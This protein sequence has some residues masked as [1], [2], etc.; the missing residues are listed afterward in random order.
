MGRWEAGGSRPPAFSLSIDNTMD[1]KHYYKGHVR[2]G[3]SDAKGRAIKF[4]E[5]SNGDGVIETSD[6]DVIAP[7]ELR[8]RER[9]GG[10][11]AISKEAF[12]KFVQEDAD[13][14]KNATPSPKPSGGVRLAQTDLPPV[15]AAGEKAV[16]AAPTRRGRIATKIVPPLEDSGQPAIPAQS[17]SAVAPQSPTPEVGAP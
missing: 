11:R 12:D 6:P 13:R 5:F 10:V 14:K 4:V 2:N 3:V 15:K 9:R 7:L 17:P 16:P 1:T 8:D